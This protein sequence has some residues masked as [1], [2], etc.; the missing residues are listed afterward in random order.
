MLIGGQCWDVM[1]LY[2]VYIIY[3]W[4]CL[5]LYCGEMKQFFLVAKQHQVYIIYIGDSDTG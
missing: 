2:H 3:V 5:Q 1:G 4:L